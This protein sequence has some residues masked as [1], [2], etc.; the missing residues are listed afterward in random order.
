MNVARMK[1]ATIR[2]DLLVGSVAASD[3]F[4]PF[5]DGLDAIVA[6][7][8]TQALSAEISGFPIPEIDWSRSE[9]SRDERDHRNEYHPASR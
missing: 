7:V 1:A 4:I 5:R 6:A 3:A 9:E 8:G 2:P